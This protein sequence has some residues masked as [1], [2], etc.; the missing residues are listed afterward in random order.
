MVC[1]SPWGREKLDTTEQLNWI[2]YLCEKNYKPIK[3]ST[4]QTIVL[5]GYLG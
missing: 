2:D 3:Y 4:V 5:V 1:Y